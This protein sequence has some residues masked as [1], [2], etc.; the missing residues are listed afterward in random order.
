MKCVYV[1]GTCDTKAEDLSY[2]ANCVR[3]VGVKA[4]VIDVSA[5]FHA[6]GSDIS[7]VEVSS[8]HPTDPNF[9]QH[10][11][12]RSTAI[13]LMSE[14]L[15]QFLL[16]S[17]EMAGVIGIGG[18]GN[19]ALI[20]SAMQKLPI[21]L[22]KLMVS[23][24]A[25]GDVGSYVGPT[26]ITMMYSVTDVAGINPISRII[27]GNAGHAIAGMVEHPISSKPSGKPL[28]GMTMY[29]VTTPAVTEI[30]RQLEE[31]FDVL[32]F[33]ANGRG[34]Q[35][36]EKLIES[37][38][39]SHI[40]DLTTTEIVDYLFDGV[41]SAGEDR[42]GAIVRTKIPF[43]G[44]VGAFDM[45]TF[46]PQESLPEAYKNRLAKRH[47]VHITLIRTNVEESRIAGKWLAKRL[48]T[49]EGPVRMMLPEKGISQLDAPGQPFY[50]PKADK[51]LFDTIIEETIQTKDRKVILLPYHI[52]DPAFAQEVVAEFHLLHAPQN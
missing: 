30:K 15:T 26:D 41:L 20:T 6:V 14:A 40:I 43:I 1:I 36:L 49:M 42:L 5:R 27:L 12:D 50:D 19:T 46:G 29:G 22:P 37:K 32:I 9:L 16:Q 10:T 8:Y 3:E 52:N 28:L 44:S 4:L 35:A 31:D 21:G 48:N 18:S 2:V 13:S 51:V 25:S 33:H 45:I 11:P 17:T 24:M 34:G 47:N 38:M 39:V 23:T 7:N